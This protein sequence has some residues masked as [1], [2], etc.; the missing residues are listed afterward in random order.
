MATS[1]PAMIPTTS[2][3]TKNMHYH[4]HMLF[5]LITVD[6]HASDINNF[7]FTK[8]DTYPKMTIKPLMM[9]IAIVNWENSPGINS[10]VMWTADVSLYIS[11]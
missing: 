5:G 10:T 3:T 4:E 6:L 7:S 1:G 8:I 9:A 11:I 2:A